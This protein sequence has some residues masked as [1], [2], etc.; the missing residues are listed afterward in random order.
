M[1]TKTFQANSQVFA[2]LDLCLSNLKESQMELSKA[3]RKPFSEGISAVFDYDDALVAFQEATTR[4]FEGLHLVDP[5]DEELLARS[6]SEED[7]E[8]E[9]RDADAEDEDEES[10]ER[11]LS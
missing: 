6:D 2:E 9:E 1:S 4:L 11:S 8:D 10:E 3:A 5:E 7:D